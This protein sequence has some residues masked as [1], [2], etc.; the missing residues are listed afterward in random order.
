[1]LTLGS[2]RSVSFHLARDDDMKGRMESA[3][4]QG[5]PHIKAEGNAPASTTDV[6]ASGLEVFWQ[7]D[8]AASL[9]D[10]VKEENLRRLSAFCM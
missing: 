9:L 1:M 8:S 4:F 3:T 5:F 10:E 7:L 6:D 2:L